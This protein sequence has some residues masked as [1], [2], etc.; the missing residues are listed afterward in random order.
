MIFRDLDGTLAGN[1]GDVVVAQD[2]ITLLNP[3]CRTTSQFDN[4]IACS[5]TTTWI[6][7]SFNAY[8]PYLAVGFIFCFILF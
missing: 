3:A 4:G 6:R 7:F 5:N 1:P 8:E 2:N